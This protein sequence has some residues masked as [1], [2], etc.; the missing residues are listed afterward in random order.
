M[1]DGERMSK[2]VVSKKKYEY[3][4]EIYFMYQD[5]PL[6][7]LQEK[8]TYGGTYY[9]LRSQANKFV[10][11]FFWKA[12]KTEPNWTLDDVIQ[13]AFDFL[14]EKIMYSKNAIEDMLSE[15]GERKEGE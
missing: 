5:I 8:R 6:A 13:N 1:K 3:T 15:D 10:M 12:I 11:L 14:V 4:G 2:I 9:E 7:V